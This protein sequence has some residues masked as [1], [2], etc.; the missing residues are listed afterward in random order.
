MSKVDIKSIVEN[1]NSNE[2]RTKE[3]KGIKTKNKI[4]YLE[5]DMNV[6]IELSDVIKVTRKDMHKEIILEFKLDENTTGLYKIYNNTYKLNIF[7]N[8][9]E[10]KDNYIEI[11]YIIE[12]DNI[13]FKLYIE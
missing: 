8:K 13:N 11:D 10:I 7:T 5:D 6:S 3:L 9:I 1:I 2:V 4:T 12:D